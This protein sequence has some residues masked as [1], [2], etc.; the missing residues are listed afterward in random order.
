MGGSYTDMPLVLRSGYD[1]GIQIFTDASHASDPDTRR[2]IMGIVVK[3]AGNTVAWTATFSR[4]V[5]HSSC[6]SELMAL[7]KGV[8]IGQFIKW[9]LEL[10]KRPT[11]APMGIF[12][13]NQAALDLSSNPIQPGRNLHIHA[14]YFY[15]RDMYMACAFALCKIRTERQIADALVTFKGGDTFNYL[16][17]L[18]MG[19]AVAVMNPE[20]HEFE[21]NESLIM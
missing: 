12:V 6:E 18:V 2:S 5:S 13:D 17:R 15:V 4:I 11:K 9:L 1:M 7:D 21:W 3:V 8:T 20:S 16:L 19:C 10:T 14:R